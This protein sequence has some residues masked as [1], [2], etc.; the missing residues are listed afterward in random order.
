LVNI[1]NL[2][3]FIVKRW[4][5]DINASGYLKEASQQLKR[6]VYY[7]F[8]ALMKRAVVERAGKWS[9]N[10]VNIQFSITN[11]ISDVILCL[12]GNR[13]ISKEVLP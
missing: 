1:F 2:N 11:V 4:T 13:K 10:F 8:A 12:S 5:L 7:A 9:K 6:K 3:R